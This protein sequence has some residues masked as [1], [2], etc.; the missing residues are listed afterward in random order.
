M[1]GSVM[2]PYRPDLGRPVCPPKR[3]ENIT[4]GAV[5]IF[6]NGE[7]LDVRQVYMLCKR[8]Y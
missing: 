6:E 8:V 1:G 7:P 3:K 2:E 4:V 5:V